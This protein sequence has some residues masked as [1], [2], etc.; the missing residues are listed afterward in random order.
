M[1]PCPGSNPANVR[2]GQIEVNEVFF[3]L[4]G[5][6][7]SSCD[8]PQR[9]IQ[10]TPPQRQQSVGSGTKAQPLEKG[11]HPVSNL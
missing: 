5:A 6:R 3:W 10:P 7:A 2:T 9:A 8:N 11:L 1:V 4:L